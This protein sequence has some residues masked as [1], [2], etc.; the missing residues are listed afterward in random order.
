MA[1]GAADF[2]GSGSY[3]ETPTGKG[4]AASLDSD[5]DEEGGGVE[6]FGRGMAAGGASSVGRGPGSGS[7]SDP[8]KDPWEDSATTASAQVATGSGVATKAGAAKKPRLSG[9]HTPRGKA[10]TPASFSST[11][12]SMDENT[13]GV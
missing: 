13:A 1:G 11:G 9:A 12:Q 8:G 4:S 10:V 5:S 6:S 3:S 7:G 2:S